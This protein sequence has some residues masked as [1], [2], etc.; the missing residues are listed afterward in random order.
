MIVCGSQ[1]GRS[2]CVVSV[3]RIRRA[4]LSVV[5]VPPACRRRRSGLGQLPVAEPVGDP[6]IPLGTGWAGKSIRESS[7]RQA[8]VWHT[9]GVDPLVAEWLDGQLDRVL[10]AQRARVDTAKLL[11]TFSTGVASAFLVGSMQTGGSVSGRMDVFAIAAFAICG[12]L[13]LVVILLDRLREPDHEAVIR[14][15]ALRAVPAGE[16]I[17][18]LRIAGLAALEFNEVIVNRV[19]SIVG[20]QL[21]SA[22]GASVL[23]G[24]WLL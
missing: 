9:P 10:A 4:E 6:S 20:W 13:A 11:V 24:I 15:S 1:P 5:A 21:V 14:A 16:M 8:S 23:S 17:A 18:E 12:A 3:H 22:V 2:A 19:R 7:W